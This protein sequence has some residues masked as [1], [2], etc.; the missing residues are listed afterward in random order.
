MECIETTEV[1]VTPPMVTSQTPHA[2]ECIESRNQVH[3]M[4][5]IETTWG[6]F[7]IEL[8]SGRNQVHAME[9][10]ET[11]AK[12][13]STTRRLFRVA[14]PLHA[15]ECIETQGADHEDGGAGGFAHHKTVADPLHAME[16]IETCNDTAYAESA[17]VTPVA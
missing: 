1:T 10:I 6:S 13:V 4:E 17:R 16:C 12:M 3:A 15:M 11:S 14:D 2:I 9:C 7:A 8:A 5:C